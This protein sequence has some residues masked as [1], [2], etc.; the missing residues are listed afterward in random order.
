MAQAHPGRT[1][2]NRGTSLCWSHSWC[3]WLQHTPSVQCFLSGPVRQ[4]SASW[5]PNRGCVIYHRWQIIMKNATAQGCW[6][7]A[8]VCK[9]GVRRCCCG[10]GNV[11]LVWWQEGRK[12]KIILKWHGEKMLP[13]NTYRQHWGTEA[14]NITHASASE[15][16]LR[17]NQIQPLGSASFPP[18]ER[19]LSVTSKRW[20]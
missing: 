1:S 9:A 14:E 11:R 12:N 3:L 7:P 16:F 2:L 10:L 8:G 15:G 17:S 5:S 13:T 4:T 20:D 19:A 6:L 18:D